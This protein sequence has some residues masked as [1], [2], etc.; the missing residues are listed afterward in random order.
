ML[1]T[2]SLDPAPCWIHEACSI[3]G[4]HL[5][6]G[7]LLRPPVRSR[8]LPWQPALAVGRDTR[9]AFPRATGVLVPQ[10]LNLLRKGFS[11]LVPA[12]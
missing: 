5:K 4:M 3:S 1:G 10:R 11:I 6:P 8:Q 12:S 2:S 9:L 7:F